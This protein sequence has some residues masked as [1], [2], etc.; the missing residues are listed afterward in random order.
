MH[1]LNSASITVQ[2]VAYPD[3]LKSSD[4]AA[5]PVQDWHFLLSAF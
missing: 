4:A 2:K 1:P 3:I 5:S